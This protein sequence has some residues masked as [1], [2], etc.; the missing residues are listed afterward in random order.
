VL[1]SPT[2]VFYAIVDLSLGIL[3]IG[4]VMLKG[5][6]IFSKITAYLGLAAGTL[7]IISAA[8]FFVTM[9]MNA[10][11]VTVWV[12]AVDCRFYRLSQQ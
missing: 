10:V 5:K 4:F 2:E 8:G 3:L 7:G 9:I 12:L 1:A 6:G 11:L